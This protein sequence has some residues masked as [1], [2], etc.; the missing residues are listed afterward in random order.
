LAR[1]DA[2]I[3]LETCAAVP[4]LYDGGASNP[5]RFEAADAAVASG[6]MMRSVWSM[7]PRVFEAPACAELSEKIDLVEAILDSLHSH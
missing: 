3:W 6:A 2:V 5:R 1:Y 7:H 4:G